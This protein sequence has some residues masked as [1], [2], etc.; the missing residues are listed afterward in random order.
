MMYEKKFKN[1]LNHREE[2][3]ELAKRRRN[4]IIKER[5]KKAILKPGEDYFNEDELLSN[6]DSDYQ[7]QDAGDMFAAY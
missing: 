2:F 7:Y 4:N 6:T 1:Y 3:R 5:K